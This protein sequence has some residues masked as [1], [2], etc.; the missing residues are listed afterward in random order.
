M[1]KVKKFLQIQDSR[2][3]ISIKEEKLLRGDIMLKLFKKLPILYQLLSLVLTTI[4]IMLLIVSATYFQ[5]NSIINENNKNAT[6]QIIH[7]YDNELTAKSD[8][9]FKI[10]LNVFNNDIVQKYIL[11]NS[12]LDKFNMREDMKNVMFNSMSIYEDILDIAIISSDGN[13]YDLKGYTNTI[14]NAVEKIKANKTV[15][16]TG[17]KKLELISN[18]PQ[19]CILA[20]TSLSS[21]LMNGS[22][23]KEI[24]KIVVVLDANKLSSNIINESNG[25]SVKYYIL[26]SDKHLYPQNNI[27]NNNLLERKNFDELMHDKAINVI[28]NKTNYIVNLNG[29]NA[30]NLKIVSLIPKNEILDKTKKLRYIDSAIFLIALIILGA[31]SL[32][33]VNNIIIPLNNLVNFMKDLKEDKYKALKNDIKLDGYAEIEI[34]AEQFNNMLT[35]IDTLNK[36]LINK[37][38]SVYE[39]EL[40]KK[41]SQL[42]YLK[43]Q[44]NP[45]FLYNTLESI[46]GIAGYRGVPEIRD[47]TQCLADIFRYSIKGSDMVLL[48]QEVD[49]VKAYISIQQIRF[50]DRFVVE[51]GFS[52]EALKCLV[53][54]MILQPLIEN[55]IYHGLELKYDAGLLKVGA[56]LL[57]N[58]NVNICIQDNGIGI[59]TARMQMINKEIEKIYFNQLSTENDVGIG[60]VNVNKRIKLTYGEEYGMKIQSKSGEGTRINLIFPGGP[61]DD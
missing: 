44:I 31:V 25:T 57:E 36:N 52:E 23:G 47:M 8:L 12:V 13:D 16:Y 58:G 38:K 45:H 43:S 50:S 49:I 30:I 48:E 34:M 39:L 19:D 33:V 29:I 14:R 40:G 27:L 37:N 60:L 24:G 35:E 54:K 46:K 32:I 59:D 11:S 4:V 41:E 9:V 18:Q 6:V 56:V 1:K 7:Q 3:N 17:F 53:P 26:D 2:Q 55:A 5:T 22:Y 61:K 20:I 15:Y 10:I 42:G 21:T 51:Y 28:L